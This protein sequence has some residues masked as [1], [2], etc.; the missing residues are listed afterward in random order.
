MSRLLVYF[1]GY[2]SRLLPQAV[3]QLKRNQS[4]K[5]DIHIVVYDQTNVSRSEKFLDV[6][7]NHV[8]WDNLTSRFKY[9]TLL[10]RRQGFD[11][12][13]YVDGSKMFEK[14]WDLEL[15]KNINERETVVS[16]NHNLVF[17][18]NKYK[19]YPKYEK[20]KIKTATETNWAVKDFLFM[21]FD[22]F[23]I[24]PD[25]SI[26]KYYGAEEYISVFCA[27]KEIPIVAVSTDLVTDND[28]DVSDKDFVPFSLYHNY[29]KVIDCFKKK[30]DHIHGV[31]K[32]MEK[33]D[34]DFASLN[35]FP[36]PCNDVEYIFVSNLD[37]MSERRFHDVQNRIY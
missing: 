5:N 13:M 3:E 25:L 24:L 26:F 16:G 21:S 19:F 9:M 11:F 18:K 23:K 37:T 29:S 4:G 32:L 7:Y 30:N 10:K 8:Y 12:F 22:L 6:E 17:D 1:Y 31:E 35:Y 20:I 33:I 36:Y 28:E 34:Y 2:K 14:D 27:D 15:L